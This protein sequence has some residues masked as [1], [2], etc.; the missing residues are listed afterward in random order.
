MLHGAL[1]S[2]EVRLELTEPLEV[3]AQ[4]QI[5]LGA[6]P[7]AALEL[8]WT[9]LPLPG[10]GAETRHSGTAELAG[11]LDRYTVRAWGELV[12]D[13]TDTRF[14]VRGAGDQSGVTVDAFEW[15]SPKGEITAG[16]RVLL[17]S[18]QWDLAVEG[19]GIDPS[20]RWTQWQG[21]IDA[22][23]RIQG[24]ATP[25]FHWSVSGIDARGTLLD[26]AV[27]ATG[28]FAARAGQWDLTDIDIRIGPNVLSASGS[29]GDAIDL[30]VTVDAPRTDLLWPPLTGSL[31]FEADIGG[32]PS[33]PGDRGR[34]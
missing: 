16:G 28:A 15:T 23:C 19:Q 5:E 14:D 12:V 2:L 4:G 7:S 32:T 11:D 20:L 27:R 6:T 22:R 10:L 13:G 9:D 29:I 30:T 17:D 25:E 24:R 18:L 31:E 34:S 33:S 26:H 21:R 3:L 1:P 8:S